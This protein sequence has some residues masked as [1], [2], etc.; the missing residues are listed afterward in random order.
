MKSESERKSLGGA[1]GH[2]VGEK[3]GVYLLLGHLQQ[4]GWAKGCADAEEGKRGILR[5]PVLTVQ[6]LDLA[7]DV[8]PLQ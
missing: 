6:L 1:P 3:G 4:A 2:L 7:S 5:F 8:Q